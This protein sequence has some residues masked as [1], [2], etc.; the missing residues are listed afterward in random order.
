MSSQLDAASIIRLCLHDPTHFSVPYSQTLH[1]LE[2]L[3]H[4]NIPTGSTVLEI[5]CGQGDCTTVLAHTIGEQGRVV[6][7][8]P[9][10]LDYGAP[11]TLGQAQ[12]HISQSPLG[13]RITWVQQSPLHYLSSLPSGK[14]FDATV[15]AHCLWYF[16]SPSLIFSTFRA[17]RPHS[18]RLL[19]AEW[20]LVAT[21]PSAQS[22][23]LAALAQAA[24][25]CRKP[26]S[27]SNI[28][29]VQSP[30]RLTKLALAAGW[31][32]ESEARVQG[33]E[34]LL[35]GQWEVSACLSPS[36]EREVEEQVSD[37]RERG[38]VLALRDAC[39]ASLEGVQGGRKGVRSMDVW[40]A[41]F[42]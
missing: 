40:V 1:R 31:Q 36:F 12:G 41:S 24:L 11:Y 20:S 7:I 29:T 16:S 4:W 3:Q 6:A 23:V 25:E 15:L 2:L 27:E 13:R 10:E 14:A 35:D 28:R 34:G 18:K 8:D 19:L 9:A 38:S 33:G 30:N 5:G 37:E 39:E 32:L 22:H 17:L 21:H 42:V 26:K